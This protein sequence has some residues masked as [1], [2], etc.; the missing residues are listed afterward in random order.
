MQNSITSSV[1][2]RTNYGF[3]MNSNISFALT[4]WIHFYLSDSTQRQTRILYAFALTQLIHAHL[5]YAISQLVHKT[6]CFKSMRIFVV[7]VLYILFF[8]VF[9]DVWWRGTGQNSAKRLVFFFYFQNILNI[10]LFFLV[11]LKWINKLQG[12]I[13]WK[14]MKT[15]KVIIISHHWPLCKIFQ[16]YFDRT[17]SWLAPNKKNKSGIVV[18]KL[19]F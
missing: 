3:L 5:I 15:Q 4:G 19:V 6:F 14:I 1:K 7:Y 2:Y 8:R 9:I 12:I 11:G 10:S 16:T 18:F 17:N 13:I